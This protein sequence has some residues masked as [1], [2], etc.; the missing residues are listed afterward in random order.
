ML[1]SV[2]SK[3]LAVARSSS[4]ALVK[5]QT[6]VV[7]AACR[8]YSDVATQDLSTMEK[9]YIAYL[10]NP[11]TDGWEIRKLANDIQGG[12]EIPDPQVL[13]AFFRACRRV[14]DYALAIRVL[15]AT[16]FKCGGQ[17]KQF[18]P[19]IMSQLKPTMD[20]LGI[21]SLEEMGYDK[22]ELYLEDVFDMH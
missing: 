8:H 17:V 16:K 20:E 7:S 19:Y 1:R 10:D 2:L 12:N 21:L 4:A 3:G 9:H 5:Q 6:P 11:D 18:W 15:E 14:N 22:P 13:C